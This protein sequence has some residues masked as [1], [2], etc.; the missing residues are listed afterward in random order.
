MPSAPSTSAGNL[1]LAPRGDFGH[2]PRLMVE[3]A[4]GSSW[5]NASPTWDDVTS[6]VRRSGGL[7]ITGSGRPDET[8]R[9]SPSAFEVLLSNRDRSLDP[10]YTG[11]SHGANV[12][13][14]K[15]VRVR[16]SW[17][18]TIYPLF[19]G[20]TAGWQP[21]YPSRA[22]DA[23][24]KLTCVDLFAILNIDFPV[25]TSFP[26]Q[27]PGARIGAVLDLIGFP[28]GLRNLDTGISLLPAVDDISGKL[29]DHCHAVAD[30]DGGVFYT[31]PQGSATYETR[32]F[33]YLSSTSSVAT[34]GDLPSENVYTNL[35]RSSNDA[36]LFT[37]AQVTPGDGNDAAFAEDATARA[38]YGPIVYSKSI[39]G[40]YDEAL[41]AAEWY[42]ARYKD[43]AV[44]FLEVQF[45][46]EGHPA[47]HWPLLLAAWNSQRYT[48]K[49]RPLGA[50]V[51]TRDSFVEKAVHE[52]VHGEWV[53][54]WSLSPFGAE[55]P[56]I[57]DNGSYVL[58]TNTIPTW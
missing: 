57:L 4:F 17:N 1:A 48:F 43:P 58:G 47:T 51:D 12:V 23:V 14:R 45:K 25:G 44:R 30:S 5:N 37:Q 16:G 28:A 19:R 56:W 33:R 15:Q 3:V 46:G 24:V 35:A 26:E 6:L 41:A 18:G 7:K 29:L 27:L 40:G 22:K 21:D 9:A 39:L 38:L 54:T 20:W 34:F 53:T 52:V 49:F 13:P 10:G 42:V 36:Y 11:G 2:Q 50:T 31:G 32:S 8:Q 55:T